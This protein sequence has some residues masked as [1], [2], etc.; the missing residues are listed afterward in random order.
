[1]KGSLKL[2]RIAGINVFVHW[3][4]SLLLLFII[5]TNIREGY[6]AIQ[7]L[8]SLFFILSIFVTV[9]LHELGHALTAKKF[10]INTKDITLLPIGGL[11]RLESIPEKPREEWLVAIAGP[12]VNLA[13]AF[14]VYF[15]VHIPEP[16]QMEAFVADGI[17]GQNFLFLFFMVNIWLSIF[18][19]LPVFPMDGGR[20]FR[21]TLSHFINRVKATKIATRL[22]QLLALGFVIGGF[23]VNPFLIF[24]GLFIMF[25]AQAELNMVS[26]RYLLKDSSIGKI[27]MQQYETLK[28]DDTISVAVQKLLNGTAKSFLVLENEKPIATLNRDAMIK[29]LSESGKDTPIQDIMDTE[30]LSFDAN[31]PIEKVYKSM[32][33]KGQELALIKDS[34]NYIGV[35][36]SENISEYIMVKNA[37]GGKY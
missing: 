33:E 30:L 13:I 31:T 36:D 28:T 12:L 17:N 20:I 6:N 10:N 23:Y 37:V 4:F 16:D 32:T 22:G 24:I 14:A 29:A 7:V 1:M 2:G 27:T 35:V 21:A 18:N 9:V 3:T 26:T 19:L 34:E 25:G 5:F 8:W 11:A 15:F